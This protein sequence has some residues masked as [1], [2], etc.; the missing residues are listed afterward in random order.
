MSVIF[1]ITGADFDLDPVLYRLPVTD[2]L[3]AM[4][5]PNR[6]LAKAGRNLAD[7]ADLTVFGQPTINAGYGEFDAGLKYI[8]TGVIETDAMSILIACKTPETS[9]SA[10]LRPSFIGN[11]SG[12]AFSIED[13]ARLSSGIQ[14]YALS[15]TQMTFSATR[16]TGPSTTTA[17]NWTLSVTDVTSW[18]F[19]SCRADDTRQNIKDLTRTLS[20]VSAVAGGRVRIPAQGAL[21]LGSAGSGS[22]NEGES[23]VAFWAV[24]NRWISD[25]EET[26]IYENVQAYLD[27]LKSITI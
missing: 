4:G 11:Q 7:G 23:H 21:R 24:Y 1:P 15:D 8:D 25:A 26:E 6:A 18:A 10:P 14:L 17:S 27:D 3:Q 22:T 16:V 5:F 9:I 20:N 13:P 2:G 12:S 19:Y